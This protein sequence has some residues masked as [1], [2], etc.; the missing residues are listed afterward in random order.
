MRILY[1]HQYFST[2]AG[3]VG[4][5]SYEFGRRLVAE[6][7]EVTVL[8]GE[9]HLT[10]VPDEVEGMRVVQIPTVC[11]N[12][13]HLLKRA[14][15]FSVFSLR[16]TWA[17]LRLDYD[18][19]LATSTPLT[20]GLPAVAAKIFRNKKFIFEVRDLWPELPKAMGVIKNPF[21]LWVLDWF[22]TRCYLNADACIGLS[23]GIVEGIRRKKPEG[24]T[25]LIPNGCDLEL[26]SGEVTERLDMP[27]GISPDDFVAIFCGAHGRANGLDAVLDAAAELRRRDESRVKLLF[28]GDG[29]LKAQLQARA[30]RENLSNCIFLD[31]LPKRDLAALMRA[32]DLG[33][34]ILADV[35]AFQFGTSPNKFFDY[36]AA[37]LPVLCNYPGWVSEMIEEWDCG[38]STAPGEAVELASAL[39]GLA[40]ARVSLPALGSNARRLATSEFSRDQ[41]FEHLNDVL[42]E[43]SAH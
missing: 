17:A 12:R 23:P 42:S 25:V 9:S 27:D 11:S 26:F 2:P 3:S 7:H 21:V 35:E 32:C 10:D 24:R 38:V 41:L 15:R 16:A 33:L 39:I 34:M 19:V 14:W 31:P 40:N 1:I 13:D 36:I 4:T 29:Q 6:G 30:D 8:C 43:V 20:V 28:V 18:L 22:E 5:R 37:G